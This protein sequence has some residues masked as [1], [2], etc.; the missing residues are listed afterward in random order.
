MHSTLTV[1]ASQGDNEVVK[2]AGP[3]PNDPKVIAAE[4]V[5]KGEWHAQ[6]IKLLVTFI[7]LFKLEQTI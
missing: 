6:L 7:E 2:V 1:Y 4:N 5:Q 3:A